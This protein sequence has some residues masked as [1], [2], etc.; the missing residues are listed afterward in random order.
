MPL[1][2]PRRDE[3]QDDFIGRCMGD[4]AM[5]QEYEDDD[6]RMAV[7]QAQWEKGPAKGKAP[8]PNARRV[9]TCQKPQLL[10]KAVEGG[11]EDGTPMFI[12]GYAA[13]WGNTD[14]GFERMMRGAFVKSIQER[15]PQG[16]VKLMVSHFC[17]GGDLLDVVGTVTE[18]KE[19]EF[20]LWFH[21]D[22]VPDDEDAAKAH[23]MVAT[24]HVGYASVGYGTV[25]YA[26]VEDD[27]GHE[28]MEHLE[29]KLY[30]VTLTVKPMNELAVLTA[31]KALDGVTDDDVNTLADVLECDPRTPDG[32]AQLQTI[33]QER[34]KAAG[35]TL[36][37][38]TAKV[39]GLLETAPQATDDGDSTPTTADLHAIKRTT[40]KCKA[41]LAMLVQE[42]D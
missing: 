11:A 21:A 35:K 1:P 14:L 4:S 38:L 41:Q 31:A 30:E 32:R 12:E 6:K 19:D 39:N 13:V 37:A 16:R 40:A 28:V 10:A 29:C 42:L 18:A 3:A 26:F 9:S 2:K 17:Y 25:K 15:V 22:M 27:A 8:D 36:E 23:N 33:G 24:G 7:C 34:V 5:Q 20:G